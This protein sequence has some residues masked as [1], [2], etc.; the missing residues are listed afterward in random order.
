MS[1]VI[2]LPGMSIISFWKV[3]PLSGSFSTTAGPSLALRVTAHSG[4]DW[5]VIWS[6]HAF[7]LRKSRSQRFSEFP[8]LF[9]HLLGPTPASDCSSAD[10]A[11]WEA[12]AS[13]AH[14]H[15][16]LRPTCGDHS[17]SPP[18]T[19]P[20]FW[21]TGVADLWKVKRWLIGFGAEAE[22][23]LPPDLRDAI[24]DDYQTLVKRARRT[25]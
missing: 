9:S 2:T 5:W 4:Q 15:P 3:L 25:I 18:E 13:F 24:L 12:P 17:Q 6:Y 20:I 22:V 21:S 14:C 1:A 11:R 19:S 7:C 16:K 8:M 23:L 10:R